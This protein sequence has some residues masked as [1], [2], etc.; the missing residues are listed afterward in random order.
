MFQSLRHLNVVTM[1]ISA[2]RIEE[3]KFKIL[4]ERQESCVFCVET[5]AVLGDRVLLGH[6]LERVCDVCINRF[7]QDGPIGGSL[8]IKGI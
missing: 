2:A 1:E 3:K 6:G 7:I 4:F 8:I 5:G